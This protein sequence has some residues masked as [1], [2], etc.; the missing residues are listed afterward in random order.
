[1][2]RALAQRMRERG[3]VPELEIFDFGML[4]YAHYLIERTSCGR[5][6]IS[7]CSWAR[8]APWPPRPSTWPR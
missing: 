8:S 4:D 1:M 2:I 5:L 3:I 7:T 6:T